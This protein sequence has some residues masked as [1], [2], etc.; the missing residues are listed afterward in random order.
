MVGDEVVAIESCPQPGLG[1]LGEVSVLRREVARVGPRVVVLVELVPVLVLF[2]V[3]PAAGDPPPDLL[4]DFLDDG[5]RLFRPF[6][7]LPRSKIATTPGLPPRAP[8][9][10]QREGHAARRSLSVARITGKAV[11]RSVAFAPSPPSK[12]PAHRAGLRPPPPLG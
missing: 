5:P 7:G 2:V 8:R 3:A 4:C 10:H 6:L 12:A 9:N 1:V 11:T